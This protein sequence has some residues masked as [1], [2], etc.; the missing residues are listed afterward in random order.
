MVADPGRAVNRAGVRNR[1]GWSFVWIGMDNV[2]AVL[3]E[4]EEKRRRVL[5]E[6]ARVE[7]VIAV[8]E[9]LAAER[10]VG[11]MPGVVDEVIDVEV[12][13]D[14]PATVAVVAA[15]GAEDSPPPPDLEP[16]SDMNFYEAAAA[17]LESVGE[18]QSSR[19]I[20]NGLEEGGYPTRSGYFCNVVGTLL[21]REESRRAYRISATPNGRRWFVRRRRSSAVRPE[22]S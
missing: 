17:Y 13:A 14:A 19:Q 9:E 12:V 6:L 1:E 11:K 7:R 16:Y 21:R 3:A 22:S 15:E 20:A 10:R 8:V 4:L 5:A 2:A 18:P